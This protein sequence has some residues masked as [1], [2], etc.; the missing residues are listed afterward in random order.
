MSDQ[1]IAETAFKRVERGW[2]FKLANPFLIGRSRYFLVD[3]AQ[4]AAIADQLRANKAMRVV[5]VIV[6]LLIMVP[7]GASLPLPEVSPWIGAFLAGLGAYIFFG[8][9]SL[10]ERHKLRPL[11]CSL[12]PDAGKIT[13]RDEFRSSAQHMSFIWL[14]FLFGAFTLNAVMV[15]ITVRPPGL[16]DI[17]ML[18][19]TI[20][21]VGTLYWGAVLIAKLRLRHWI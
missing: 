8:A 2:I 14:S 4:K 3:D 13:L 9:V 18:S 7:I 20:F 21:G 17:K 19:I 1:G 16:F 5:A 12:P 11:I 10:V 6:T 15:A